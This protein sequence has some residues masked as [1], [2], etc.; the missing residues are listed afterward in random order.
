M[1]DGDTLEMVAEPWKFRQTRI[2]DG[3]VGQQTRQCREETESAT[4]A[5]IRRQEGR[6]H[7]TG[8]IGVNLLTVM[9]LSLLLESLQRITELLEGSRMETIIRI[10]NTLVFLFRI[11]PCRSP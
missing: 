6:Y 7:H 1:V 10:A 2:T 5:R 8:T 4:T 11:F 3:P 9:R